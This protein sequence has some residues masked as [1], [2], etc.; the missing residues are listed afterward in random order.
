MNN[1]VL[2]FDTTLR[3]GEQS[4][5]F[6]MN[7]GEKL[8]IAQQLKKLNV[9]IIEA[10]FPIASVGDFEAVKMIAERIDGPRIVGL[11][12]TSDADV[13][14]AWEAVQ[15]ASN[16][17]IHT[18]IATSDLHIK[19]KL[20]STR[21]KVMREVVR[22]VKRA[23]NYTENV[24]FSA[25][26]ATRSDRAFLAEVLEAAIEAGATCLNIPDTVGY[27]VP[28][29]YAG[30]IT[31]IRK[32]VR[33]AERVTLSVH[34]HDDL[35]LA[36]ANSLAAILAGARQVECTINGIGERAGNAS[37]EEIVM[38]LNTRR[39]AYNLSTG[40]Q[41]DQIFPASRLVSQITG[42]MVPPNKAIVGGN[43]FAHEAG[44]HQDGV[45][46]KTL[47]YEIMTPQSVG[48]PSN[49]LVLGKHSGRHA[50]RV[51][52][53]QLGFELS[54][55]NL[56]KA[57]RKFKALADKKKDIYD[58]D[59]IALV[60]EEIL[61]IPD[62]YNLISMNCTCGSDMQ[63]VA[64]VI[65][66]MDGKQVKKAGF[67]DGPVDAIYKT[68]STMTGTKSK[69]LRF[70]I[71]AITGGTDAQG[72]VTI[73]LEEEGKRAVGQGT[74]TDILVASA[75]AYVNALNKLEYYRHGSVGDRKGI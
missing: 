66:E 39:D 48:V 63:P 42:I 47:T 57:F 26:D 16:N 20:K 1:R 62:K 72:G 21:S 58:E 6:S 56:N 54:E 11:A 9:D 74:H 43:A 23:R 55:E 31:E 15:G 41:T 65:L 50:F 30:L 25:E 10:G 7:V 17:G 64:T 73:H 60:A 40:I 37:M 69:L 13:D 36:V 75:K 52:I 61:R 46:K 12:R 22:A 18:F 27:T 70:V 51:R 68:I 5:G 32:R 49:T 33:G 38:C 35:G 53:E 67:G 34:C 19:Y 29:E 44:I 3:D 59:L 4:P 14:R 8:R 71:S 2:I 45:L 24:E 28:T